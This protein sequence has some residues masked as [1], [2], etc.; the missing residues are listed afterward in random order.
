MG[1]SI[2]VYLEW[3]R[4]TASPHATQKTLLGKFTAYPADQPGSFLLRASKGFERLKR[5]GAN[6]GADQTVL[7]LEMKRVHPNKP[8]APIRVTIGP[9]RWRTEL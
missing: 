4:P 5:M 6:L 1:F 9:V 8:W 2:F 3:T 7:F